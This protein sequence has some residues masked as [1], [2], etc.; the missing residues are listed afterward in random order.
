MHDLWLLTSF[1]VVTV[2]R[3]RNTEHSPPDVLL[4]CHAALRKLQMDYLDL[5][6]IH[7]PVTIRKGAQ[8]P[9]IS[10]EDKLGYNPERVAAT[11]AVRLFCVI[12]A[13]GRK[14]C[15]E[16]LLLNHSYQEVHVYIKML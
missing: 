1:V 10:D 9:N 5:Y 3:A 7:W 15:M 13:D 8:A 12:Y 11:W 4:A 16:S 2:Y 6:L 14:I